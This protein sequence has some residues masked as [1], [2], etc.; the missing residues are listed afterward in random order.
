MS[1]TSEQKEEL[2][3]ILKKE[4]ST[5]GDIE[6]PTQWQKLRDWLFRL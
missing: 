3:M 5:G 4:C 2:K 6:Y 1:M